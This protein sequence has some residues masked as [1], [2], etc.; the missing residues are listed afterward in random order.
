LFVIGRNSSFTYKGRAVDLKEVGRELGVRY[1]LE[2]SVRRTNKR[3]RI[4]AQLI[5]ATTG[6]HIW[7]DKF[8][9]EFEDIFDL[10]DRVTNNVIGAISPRLLQ[11]EFDR[12][13]RKPTENLQAYDHVLRALACTYK[14]RGGQRRGAQIR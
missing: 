10:Q 11:A 1:V 7:A 6:A 13:Q 3:I 4:T 8:D 14:Y 5:D 9:S 12:I 2:G